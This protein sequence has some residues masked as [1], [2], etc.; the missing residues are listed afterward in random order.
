MSE[1]ISHDKERYK[2]YLDQDHPLL[3]ELNE[4]CKGT[5]KHS[6]DVAFMAETI[7]RKLEKASN[8]RST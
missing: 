2:Q 7:A 6:Q 4:K 5:F 1:E 3:K 8:T